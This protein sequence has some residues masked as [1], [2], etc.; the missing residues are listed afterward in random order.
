MELVVDLFQVG[1]GDMG[2]YLGGG[3]VTVAQHGLNG[4]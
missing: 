1:I 3:H 2:V 4:A